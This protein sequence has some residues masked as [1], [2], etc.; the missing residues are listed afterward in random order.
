MCKLGLLLKL[1]KAHAAMF[2]WAIAD[3][4]LDMVGLFSLL[5]WTIK[6]TLWLSRRNRSA[7]PNR[8]RAVRLND[9]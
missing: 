5:Y 1:H 3:R 8:P 7:G 4:F 6:G 2:V 9:E